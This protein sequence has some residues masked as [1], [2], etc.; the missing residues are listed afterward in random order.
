M[1]KDHELERSLGG[2]LAFL[3]GGNTR[4]NEAP[5]LAGRVRPNPATLSE[6]LNQPTIVHSKDAEPKCRHTRFLKVGLNL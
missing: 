4:P 5:D 2:R 3:Y 1:M 6:P